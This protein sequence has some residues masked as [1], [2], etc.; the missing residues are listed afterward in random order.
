MNVE[1]TG[2]QNVVN[3]SVPLGFGPE[4][5]RTFGHPGIA[6]WGTFSTADPRLQHRHAGAAAFSF[7][8][9]STFCFHRG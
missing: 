7:P 4:M 9:G 8:R 5:P 1:S 3:S 2:R 6:D